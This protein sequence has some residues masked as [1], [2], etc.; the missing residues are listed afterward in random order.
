MK[1]RVVSLLVGV[2]V[3][4]G[5]C[6][7]ANRRPYTE[8]SFLSDSSADKVVNLWP[9]YNG[10]G[11]AN[12]VAWPF[13]KWSSGCFAFLP[14]YNY[15]HGI[16]DICLLAT[17]VPKDG[18]YRLF[19]IFYRSPRAFYLFPFG[20]I[21]N[22]LRFILPL[23]AWSF[24]KYTPDYGFLSLLYSQIY[25]EYGGSAEFKSFGPLWLAG[26]QSRLAQDDRGQTW[27]RTHRNSYVFPLWWQ[28][29]DTSESN[30]LLLPLYYAY[31]N[32]S[33]RQFYTLP[34]GWRYSKE[35]ADY[36]WYAA[37]VG[38]ERNGDTFRAWAFPL[39]K[40]RTVGN[41][42][43]QSLFP[44]YWAT[45]SPEVHSCWTPV[46]GWE[47]TKDTAFWYALNAGYNRKG[48]ESRAWF[49]P[50]YYSHRYA[51]ANK[52]V[53][54]LVGWGAS[55]DASFGYALNAG[56]AAKGAV[57]RAWCLP[58]WFRYADKGT[59]NKVA[60]WTPLSH[61]TT[62]RDA[63]GFDSYQFHGGPLGLNFPIS[64]ERCATYDYTH[65]FPFI[66][67]R[68]SYYTHGANRYGVRAVDRF[69]IMGLAYAWSR[70]YPLTQEE[71]LPPEFSDEAEKQGHS[72]SLLSGF[73]THTDVTN[74]ARNGSYWHTEHARS[75]GWWLYKYRTETMPR[76]QET[77]L[78]TPLV[79]WSDEQYGDRT[80]TVGVLLDSFRRRTKS[81]EGQV[82]ST[83]YSLFYDCLWTG[84]YYRDGTCRHAALGKALYDYDAGATRTKFDVMG[85]LIGN[86]Y[87]SETSREVGFLADSFDWSWRKS[88]DG[89][90]RTNY[91]LGYGLLWKGS[92]ATNGDLSHSA[93]WTMLYSYESKRSQDWTQ[94]EFNLLLGGLLYSHKHSKNFNDYSILTPLIYNFEGE[95]NGSFKQKTLCGLLTEATFDA[96]KQVGT[97][98]IL[99]YLYRYNLYGDKTRVHTFFPFVKYQAN[100]ETQKRSYSFLH[101]FI[102]YDSSPTDSDFWFAFIPLW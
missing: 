60:T 31:N 93:G 90:I 71:P 59:A 24:D 72:F 95:S 66:N 34:V 47:T 87:R 88:E 42:S 1:I 100:P 69:G 6:V 86:L 21:S 40:H 84:N 9:I 43:V 38:A 15:D 99:K 35:N 32:S 79:S 64:I 67:K 16:H 70:Y 68:T 101:K 92:F 80:T 23:V 2:A 46:F 8:V 13:V 81:H 37:N 4:L 30:H 83:H 57:S 51:D 65:I 39:W 102:R 94:R 89:T 48:D 33:R 7:S 78:F 58:F 49:M 77:H 50:L 29:S 96:E 54:P 10:N 91:D 36:F 82:L 85:G 76:S 20:Q 27:H 14:F 28:W 11:T 63:N 97:F 12:Y 26:Y 52:I 22:D 17:A 18:E 19:P 56:F 55:R 25:E 53:T 3:L 75:L 5:G 73:F 98:G 61:H 44:L 41:Q 74:R 45:W 62:W